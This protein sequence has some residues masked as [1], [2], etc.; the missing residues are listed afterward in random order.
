MGIITAEE[1]ERDMKQLQ[2]AA[3][4]AMSEAG[5]LNRVDSELVLPPI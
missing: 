1:F 3:S 2:G 5:A 4:A